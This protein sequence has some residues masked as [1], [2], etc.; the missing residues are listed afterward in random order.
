MSNQSQNP[1]VDAGLERAPEL[2]R[3]AGFNDVPSGVDIAQSTDWM[4]KLANVL[5]LR[6]IDK[7]ERSSVKD[8]AKVIVDVQGA[9]HKTGVGGTDEDL[10]TIIRNIINP[11]QDEP[12][13]ISPLTIAG[14]G[15]GIE[16]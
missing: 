6:N 10:E 14:S 5:I 11:K 1:G 4:L 2:L 3:A 7:L 15:E 13:E 9:F 12:I 16:I 8:T